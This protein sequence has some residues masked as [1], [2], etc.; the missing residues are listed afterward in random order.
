MGLTIV[1]RIIEQH[2][3]V[4]HLTPRSSSGLCAQILLPVVLN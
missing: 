3:G 2:N 4:L 1:Q